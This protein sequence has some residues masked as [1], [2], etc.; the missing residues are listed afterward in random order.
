MNLEIDGKVAIVFAA[1]KGLG[2]A[3]ALALAGEG[4]RIAICSRNE[5]NLKKA[6]KDIEENSGRDV[7]IGIVDL[8]QEKEI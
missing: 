3:A 6:A 7:L 1:S 2:K 8:S 5:Q 4:C